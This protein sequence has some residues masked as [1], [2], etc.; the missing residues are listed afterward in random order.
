MVFE[1]FGGSLHAEGDSLPD[2]TSEA[3]IASPES[4]L[5][6]S[7]RSQD[8]AEAT[9]FVAER[10]HEI[11]V[12]QEKIKGSVSDDQYVAIKIEIEKKREEIKTKNLEFSAKWLGNQNEE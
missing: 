6:E 7:D 11:A 10:M 3:P 1:S 4:S 2:K 8:T 5:S 12:L 9:K